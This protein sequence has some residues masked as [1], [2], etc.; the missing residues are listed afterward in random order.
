VMATG[1]GAVSPC[2]GGVLINTSRMKGVRVDPEAQ[3]A[4]VEPGALWTD[5]IPEAQVF[6]LAELVVS[7]SVVAVVGYTIGGG[8]GWLGRKYGFHADSMR[9]ADVVSADGELLEVSTYEHPDL[10]WGLKGGGNFGIVTS[11]EFALYPLTTVYGWNLFCASSGGA[12]GSLRPD[13]PLPLR[14]QHPALFGAKVRSW[15]KITLLPLRQELPSW[16]AFT[17]VPRR[18]FCDLCLDGALGSSIIF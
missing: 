14:P 8:F 13:Q 1:H 17:E 11:M 5:V 15:K 2:D 6:G 9:E 16:V 18:R 7:S 3:T 4:R 10:F 12:Q